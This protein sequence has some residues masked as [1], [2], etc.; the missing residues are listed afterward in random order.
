MVF[1]MNSISD[2]LVQVE[3]GLWSSKELSQ[4]SFPEEE[5]SQ[6]AEIEEISFWYQFRRKVISLLLKDFKP[7]GPLIDVGGGSG[8]NAAGLLADD[9]ETI[10]LEPS[11]DGVREA[12]KKGLPFIVASSFDDCQFKNDS[13]AGIGLFDVLEHIEND[14]E[15]LDKVYKVL[16]PGGIFILTVPAYR[17]LWSNEDEYYGHFRRY[18]LNS[19]KKKLCSYGFRVEYSSYLF[20]Y[21]VLPIFLFRSIPSRL[22]LRLKHKISTNQKEHKKNSGI[23][24]KILN[25]MNNWELS[26]FKKRSKIPFGSSCVVVVSK[27]LSCSLK[28]S[29]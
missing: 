11:P 17:L 29:K 4:I 8:F 6:Q 5:N 3:E 28:N 27:P 16:K 13:V 9:I 20:S 22:H 25:R 15:F 14:D 10:L 26:R 21:L 23:V 1:L 24:N 12:Q 7:S 18:R 19:L 2:K